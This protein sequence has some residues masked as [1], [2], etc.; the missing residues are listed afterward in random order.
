MNTVTVCT[1]VVMTAHHIQGH[2]CMARHH[3][4]GREKIK[5]LN[6]TERSGKRKY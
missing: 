1:R 6:L 3:L 5:G 4:W 2:Q